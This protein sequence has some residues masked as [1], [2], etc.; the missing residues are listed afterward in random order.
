MSA[1]TNIDTPQYRLTRR[2]RLAVL[3]LALLVALAIG[4]MFAGGSVATNQS[5]Q[6]HVVVVAAGDTLWDIADDAPGDGD[7]VEMMGYLRDLNSLD[8]VDLA[9][10][11]QLQVPG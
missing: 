9:V 4:V 11:Q 6:T 1:T 7:V 10:G 5:G 3:G 2:G 8:S